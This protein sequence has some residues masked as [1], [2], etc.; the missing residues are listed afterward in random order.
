MVTSPE[1]LSITVQA[2]VERIQ[3]EA[4]KHI[5]HSKR[6]ILANLLKALGELVQEEMICK[7]FASVIDCQLAPLYQLVEARI[8]SE[9]D[10]EI[11]SLMKSFVLC[12]EQTGMNLYQAVIYL[13]EVIGDMPTC[14]TLISEL[15]NVMLKNGGR[16]FVEH[17]M[18]LAQEDSP[19]IITIKDDHNLSSFTKELSTLGYA[20]ANAAYKWQ[21]DLKSSFGHDGVVAASNVC[22]LVIHVVCHSNPSTC[23]KDS[24]ATQ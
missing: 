19:E 13:S 6:V 12:S 24:K 18:Q 1:A 4:H 2:I 7:P 11:L 8:I 17:Q 5:R 10:Q 22:Q 9:Y 16:L 21:S 14:T 15:V 20:M 3:I 23:T